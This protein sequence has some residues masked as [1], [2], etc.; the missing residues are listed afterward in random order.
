MA[1]A[2]NDHMNPIESEKAIRHLTL[3]VGMKHMRGDHV[4]SSPTPAPEKPEFIVETFHT[5]PN[6]EMSVTRPESNV[7]DT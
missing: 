1:K 7:H 6:G 3:I 2:Q 5:G 4:R